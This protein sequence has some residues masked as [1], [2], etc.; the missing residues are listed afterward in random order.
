MFLGNF[1][2]GHSYILGV[3]QRMPIAHECD[4]GLKR[5]FYS[6]TRLRSADTE[7]LIHGIHTCGHSI[8]LTHSRKHLRSRFSVNIWGGVT[9]SQVVRPFVLEERFTSERRLRFLED[10]LPSVVNVPVPI[11]REMWLQQTWRTPSFFRQVTISQSSFSEPLDRAAGSGCL[12]TKA[13]WPNSFVLLSLG[14]YEVS[15]VCT[16]AELLNRIMDA[17]AHIRNDEPSL[18]GSV[19]SYTKGHNVHR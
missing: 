4:F 16:G 6:P 14:T 12:A 1:G 2:I 10:E 19:T 3:P 11:R 13:T 7:W 18:T 17:S 8:I 5:K 9:A 15:G